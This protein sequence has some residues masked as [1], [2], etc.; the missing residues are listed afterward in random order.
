MSN[1]KLSSYIFVIFFCRCASL[2]NSDSEV[3]Y[4]K[5]GC[6]SIQ[7]PWTT[8]TRQAL[9]PDSPEKVCDNVIFYN[10]NIQNVSFQVYP[11]VNQQLTNLFDETKPTY[12]ISHGF[13][14]SGKNPWLHEMAKVILNRTVANVF[15]V[16]WEKGAKGQ[17]YKAIGNNRMAAKVISNVIERLVEEKQANLTNFDLIGHSLG[18]HLSCYVGQNLKGKVGRIYALDPAGPSFENHPEEIR[19]SPDDALHVE[20]HHTNI[21]SA[22]VGYAKPCGTVD[23]YYNNGYVQPTCSGVPKQVTSCS[24]SLVYR[25][26]MAAFRDDQCFIGEPAR[27]EEFQETNVGRFLR[28]GS[29]NEENAV[30]GLNKE[31]RPGVY[32]V[33]TNVN[34]FPYCK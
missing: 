15:I 16:N 21:G 34:G 22:G 11:E 29:K 5:V 12:F 33:F 25:Y 30:L 3:C 20:V 8:L 27:L 28:T 24:H 32:A 18:A 1:T 9:P 2:N 19:C 7:A 17:Y 6:F 23:F 31:Y 26:L 10:E 4:N 14:G 13:H